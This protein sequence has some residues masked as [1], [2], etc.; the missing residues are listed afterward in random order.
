MEATNRTFT[1]VETGYKCRLYTSQDASKYHLIYEGQSNFITDGSEC[2][3]FYICAHTPVTVKT[4]LKQI[5]KLNTGEFYHF[6][7][8]EQITHKKYAGFTKFTK[9]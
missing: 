1:D 6:K 8:D 4:S 7:Q 3:G 9:L 5:V 2:N